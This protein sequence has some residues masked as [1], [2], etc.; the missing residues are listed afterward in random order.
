MISGVRVESACR[1]DVN[2]LNMF[3]KFAGNT[4]ST[5]THAL[6]GPC[7]DISLLQECC[8]DRF[9]PQLQAH[10]EN[11]FAFCSL[12]LVLFHL[13]KGRDQSTPEYWKKTGAI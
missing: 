12:L 10:R 5:H 2:E 3:G 9:T 7:D 8:M 1:F 6:H 13:R 11:G 4:C